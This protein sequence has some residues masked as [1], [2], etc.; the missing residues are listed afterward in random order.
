M[1]TV[2][3][4]VSEASE[5]VLDWLVAKCEGWEQLDFPKGIL[6]RLNLRGQMDYEQPRK[7]ST[8][9]AHGGPIIERE[10]ISLSYFKAD[11]LNPAPYV[12]AAA[13]S[14]DYEGERSQ[15]KSGPTPLI[16]AMRCRVAS[17]LGSTVEVP[18]ELIN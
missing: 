12:I 7:Y 9:W 10:R 8:D 3:I 4:N 13:V 2:E 1:S 6:K 11:P 5:H 16:A 17:K 15:W 18:S 14:S